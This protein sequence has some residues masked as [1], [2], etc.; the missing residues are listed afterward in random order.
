MATPKTTYAATFPNGETITRTSARTYTHAY[1]VTFRRIAVAGNKPHQLEWNADLDKTY[2]ATGFSGSEALAR[3][4]AAPN[5]CHAVAE[6]FVVPV[7]VVAPAERKAARRDR[8]AAKRAL[9][10]D[11]EDPF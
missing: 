4:A 7:T 6:L 11:Q 1:Y 8:E 2:W 10:A 3:K 9:E 5:H